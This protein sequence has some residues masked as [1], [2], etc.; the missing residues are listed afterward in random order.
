[1]KR[2]FL[3]QAGACST[4]LAT[5][6]LLLC[7]GCVLMRGRDFGHWAQSGEEIPMVRVTGGGERPAPPRDAAMAL[8][9]AL[10]DMPQP[11]LDTLDK[12]LL[13]QARTYL[14]VNVVEVDRKGRLG[15]YITR[16]NLMPIDGAFNAAEAGRLGRLL[17]V[18]Y[19]LCVQVQ[20][21]RLDPPQILSMRL[22]LIETASF[23]VMTELTAR[24]DATEQTTLVAVEKFLRVRISRPYSQ[25]SLDTV[26]RSP[27]E[28]GLF[29]A[30][31]CMRAVA[32]AVWREREKT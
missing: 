1:M 13:E 11:Q 32:M 15:P 26:L 20:H 23:K 12:N 29:A 22:A 28:F 25:T 18:P 5:V 9:P 10:S 2:L 17:D 27:T 3:G 16:E 8:L 6:A 30:A 31:H 21:Y 24:F 7:G 4:G 14:P 19:V